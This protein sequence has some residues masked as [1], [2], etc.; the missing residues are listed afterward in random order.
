[1]RA[2]PVEGKDTHGSAGQGVQQSSC[3]DSACGLGQIRP[4]QPGSLV[5]PEDDI[6][7]AAEGPAIKGENSTHCVDGERA[8]QDGGTY[9][10][11]AADDRDDTST[12]HAAQDLAK[13]YRAAPGH[14]TLWTAQRSISWPVEGTPAEGAG[15]PEHVIGVVRLHSRA[16]TSRSD[17]SGPAIPGVQPRQARHEAASCRQSSRSIRELDGKMGRPPL[18]GQRG[19]PNAPSPGGEELVRRAQ[20][21]GSAVLIL[22]VGRPISKPKAEEF[23]RAVKYRHGRRRRIDSLGTG[24]QVTGERTGWKTLRGGVEFHSS[25]LQATTT[26]PPG[27]WSC[28]PRWQPSAGRS[29]DAQSR[30]HTAMAPRLPGMPSL[31]GRP[32]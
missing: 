21:V 17:A 7:P 4:T 26:H 1:M 31:R 22:L 6:E 9:S 19:P 25:A 16:A 18:G 29:S 28:P 8:G 12:W 14:L 15:H 23:F 30:A 11:G 32:G 2:A 5:Q 24:C 3:L 27:G 20:P 10:A 13:R